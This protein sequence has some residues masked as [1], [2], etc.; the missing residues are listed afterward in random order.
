MRSVRR[1]TVRMTLP[2]ALSRTS[3]ARTRSFEVTFTLI[4]SPGANERCCGHVTFGPAA[5]AAV[6]MSRTAARA[7]TRRIGSI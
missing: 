2:L 1:A 6:G 3:A 7:S 4:V 5:C